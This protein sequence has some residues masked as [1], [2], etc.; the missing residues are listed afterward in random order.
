MGV[1]TA[2]YVIAHV[3]DPSVACSP[4]AQHLRRDTSGMLTTRLT[5]AVEEGELLY[6]EAL[7][8]GESTSHSEF[9]RLHRL[10]VLRCL[11]MLAEGF[12]LEAVAEFVHISNRI[13]KAPSPGSLSAAAALAMWD[14][15]ELLRGL[16]STL[17]RDDRG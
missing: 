12:E 5:A 10:W 1:I 9:R 17:H 8:C 3:Y 13:T 14:A 11:P 15:L 6:R 2:S 7:L 4:N 16:R